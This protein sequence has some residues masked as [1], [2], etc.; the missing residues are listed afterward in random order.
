MKCQRVRCVRPRRMSLGNSEGVHLSQR[1]AVGKV[2]LGNPQLA[3]DSSHRANDAVFP[4]ASYLSTPTCCLDHSD[5]SNALQ[6]VNRAPSEILVKRDVHL[7]VGKPR[8]RKRRR[9]PF[10]PMVFMLPDVLPLPHCWT[11]QHWH[12]RATGNWSKTPGAAAPLRWECF[13]FRLAQRPNTRRRPARQATPSRARRAL[14]QN[15]GAT[16]LNPCIERRA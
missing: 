6:P 5:I 15:R 2:A 9:K 8:V 4:N 16:R 11:S 12:P 7:K 14:P 3:S 1:R 13:S 10:S